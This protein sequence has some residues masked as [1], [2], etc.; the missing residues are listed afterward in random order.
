MRSCGK[1]QELRC[2]PLP[3]QAANDRGRD[4]SG[5][6]PASPEGEFGIRSRSSPHPSL[7]TIPA[8]NIRTHRRTTSVPSYVKT[9]DRS[10]ET[11]SLDM[12]TARGTNLSYESH[13]LCC[14]PGLCFSDSSWWGRRFWGRWGIDQRHLLGQRRE[15]CVYRCKDSDALRRFWERQRRPSG[16]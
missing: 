15:G 5:T 4:G 16:V 9:V 7:T 12:R 2:S 14:V 3:R 10:C 11:L 13:G 8:Q 1:V 6:D